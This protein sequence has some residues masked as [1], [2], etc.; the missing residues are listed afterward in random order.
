MKRSFIGKL[1]V[2]LLNHYVRGRFLMKTV[3]VEEGLTPVRDYLESQGCQVVNLANNEDR[4]SGASVMVV[5]GMD[6]N[7]MGM[8][9]VQQNIPVISA[10][11]LSPEDVYSRV[12]SHLHES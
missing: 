3:A 1:R 7:L 11:G 12:K 10:E 6:K 2:I 4:S 8:Q 5:T 9:S